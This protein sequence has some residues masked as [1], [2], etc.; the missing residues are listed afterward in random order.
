MCSF[1]R[2]YAQWTNCTLTKHHFSVKAIIIS[3]DIYSI[4]KTG[5]EK[6]RSFSN[7]VFRKGTKMRIE[8]MDQWRLF[9]FAVPK[10]TTISLTTQG[11]RK[12]SIIW[13]TYFLPTLLRNS[14]SG[15]L[16]KLLEASEGV[17]AH[18]P[19]C[20]IFGSAWLPLQV[21]TQLHTLLKLLSYLL[22]VTINLMRAPAALLLSEFI[23]IC[24]NKRKFQKSLCSSVINY[25]S[26]LWPE[27]SLIHVIL[28]LQWVLMTV[29]T[30]S[31]SK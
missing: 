3:F 20:S 4:T 5:Q 11:F 1:Y 12:S 22:P 23:V 25:Q 7:S 17:L 29:D 27:G 24:L 10:G 18:L 30:F 31:F 15:C 6:W 19:H 9:G 21:C 28:H 13:G 26:L 8:K 16:Q 2:N 14:S